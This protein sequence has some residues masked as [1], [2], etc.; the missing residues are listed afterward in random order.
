VQQDGA[1]VDLAL[2]GEVHVRNAAEVF[3]GELHDE[4]P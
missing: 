1:L 3:K 4:S 2:E